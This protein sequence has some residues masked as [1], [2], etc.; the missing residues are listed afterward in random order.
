MLDS[1]ADRHKAFVLDFAA[2]PFIDTT[3]A[4]SIAGVVRN[5]RRHKVAVVISGAAAD[6]RQ[7]LE[8]RGINSTLAVFCDHVDEAIGIA[9]TVARQKVRTNTE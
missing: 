3:A 1:I 8:A 6:I 7:A 9:H 5:A 2:V 4:N